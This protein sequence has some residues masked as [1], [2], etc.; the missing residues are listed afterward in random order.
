MNK[1]LLVILLLVSAAFNLAVVGSFIYLRSTRPPFPPDRFQRWQD[2]DHHRDKEHDGPGPMFMFDDSIKALHQAFKDT[3]RE[4]MLELA[5]EPLDMAKIDAIVARSLSAQAALERDLA[6]RLIRF[7]K[8]LTPEEAREHFTRR[9]EY[10]P[11]RDFN[12]QNHKKS[13]RSRR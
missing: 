12:R 11:R 6:D 5:K 4:L 1:R 9:A 7:R 8:S 13:R 3:K 2:R 10:E